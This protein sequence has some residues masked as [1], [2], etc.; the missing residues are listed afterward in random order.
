MTVSTAELESLFHHKY[1]DPEVIGWG[2]RRR[3]RFGYFTPD[4][5][6][7]ATVTKLVTPSTQW[8]DVGCGRDIFP[9][10]PALARALASRCKRLVGLDISD[11]L[12]ENDIVH[13][14][15]KAAVED[16]APETPFNLVTLRM[17]AEHVGNPDGAVKALA[18]ITMIGGKVVIFTVCKFSPITMISA[19]MPFR[20]HHPLKAFLWQTEERDTF[21][22]EYRMNTRRQLIKLFTA[23]G[24]REALFERIDDCRTFARFNMLN[25]M[26]LSTWA[27]CR[28][29][30][31]FYPEH[32]L[33]GIY[34]RVSER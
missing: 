26:E 9:D 14:R 28:R 17:V 30:G 23:A 6:Y 3:L 33:L 29:L 8:L 22:T 18:R 25:W 4:D 32:C 1:G 12:D 11:N 10:N 34:E 2:P 13:E 27:V 7:E 16:Y 24:F 20:A 15:V 31:L 19:L 5:V 21:P